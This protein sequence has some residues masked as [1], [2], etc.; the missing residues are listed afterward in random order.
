MLCKWYS[1]VLP[2]Y[3]RYYH[4]T[5]YLRYNHLLVATTLDDKARLLPTNQ[6]KIESTVHVRAALMMALA[7]IFWLPS[8]H[9]HEKTFKDGRFDVCDWNVS[10]ARITRPRQIEENWCTIFKNQFVGSTRVCWLFTFPLCYITTLS[11][12]T[13]YL[14]NSHGW[15]SSYCSWQSGSQ[16]R[17]MAELQMKIWAVSM[18]PWTND[19]RWRVLRSIAKLA[20]PKLLLR[21]GSSGGWQL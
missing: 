9:V 5:P 13:Q 12:Q 14:Q 4:H 16:G 20:I 3:N 10:Q 21:S 1:K 6:P 11:V 19:P 8:I 15:T 7:L 18:Q 17:R 2:W